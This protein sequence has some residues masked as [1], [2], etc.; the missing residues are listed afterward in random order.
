MTSNHKEI[1]IS[2]LVI[3]NIPKFPYSTKYVM[4]ASSFNSSPTLY[5]FDVIFVRYTNSS[6]HAT[7]IEKWQEFKRFLSSGG[8]ACFVGIETTIQRYSSYLTD[9]SIP[10]M[11]L[12]NGKKVSWIKG[13]K[14]YESLKEF[15]QVIY[16]AT[17]KRENEG[18][19]VVLGRSAANEAISFEISFGKGR[20][21]FLPDFEVHIR[22][23]AIRNLHKAFSKQI[24]Q[25]S[26]RSKIPMWYDTVTLF[27][28]ELVKKEIEVANLKLSN[29][30][31]AKRTLFEEGKNLSKQYAD[32]FEQML[33]GEGFEVYWKEESGM[34]D[35]E[36]KS[37]SQIFVAEIRA[38]NGLV[39]VD[40]A[41]QLM[42][43]IQLI[44]D[45]GR[46]KKGILIGNPYR[47]IAPNDRKQ[48][49]SKECIDLALRNNFCLVNSIQLLHCYDLVMSN[50]LTPKN[51]MDRIFEC[52]GEFSL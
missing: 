10:P 37:K 30:E 29:I 2:T 36:I 43:H 5:D 1:R 52:N 8:I 21:L 4:Y 7:T 9:S 46:D 27:C 33:Q 20:L 34:H 3:G 50:K 15:D 6:F 35:L 49:Y 45:A 31:K 42:D 17:I 47:H 51:L 11:V 23:K 38:S 32:I 39:N 19:I 40:L 13:T 22:L 14:A 44:K 26:S 28:E 18:G 12:K 41:R 25:L 48:S 24:I 16:N